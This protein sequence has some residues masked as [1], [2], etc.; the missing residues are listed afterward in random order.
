MRAMVFLLIS[1]AMLAAC[2][3]T[4]PT[5]PRHSQLVE[6]RSISQLGE[7][8]A[9]GRTTSEAL[10]TAYLERIEKI[11]RSGPTLRAIISINPQALEQARALDAERRPGTSVDRCMA[12][13]F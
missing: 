1:A 5:A 3:T 6:E 4:T 8:L 7:D 11:D 10:V 13:R 9:A 2:A 12:F